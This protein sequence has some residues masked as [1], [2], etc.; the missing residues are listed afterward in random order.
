V[1]GRC[2]VTLQQL[3]DL[4]LKAFAVELLAES[5]N[6]HREKEKLRNPF[7]F[8][9]DDVIFT[10]SLMPERTWTN[11]TLQE[12]FRPIANIQDQESFL[13]HFARA[14]MSANDEERAQLTHMALMLVEK[15]SLWPA[16]LPQ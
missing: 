11:E 14:F 16:E 1:R 4:R 2:T 15:Y 12:V 9:F 3:I 10:L 6:G 7:S 8:A 5:I 13:I